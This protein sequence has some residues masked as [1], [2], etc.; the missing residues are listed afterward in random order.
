[1]KRL[2]FIFLIFL[3]T[4]IV[5]ANSLV[6]PFI[7]DD[8]MLIG[9][10]YQIKHHSNFFKIFTSSLA[11][12][13]YSNSTLTIYYRPIQTL[14]YIFDYHIFRLNPWGY[15]L[16]NVLLHVVCVLLIYSFISLLTKDK[17]ISIIT[18][19]LFAVHPIH[20]EAVTYISGRADILAAIFFLLTLIIYIRYLSS[21]KIRG[22]YIF[23]SAFT[24]ILSILCKEVVLVLPFIIILYNFRFLPNKRLNKP[25][26]IYLIITVVYIAVSYFLFGF[27]KTHLLSYKSSL[28]FRIATALKALFIYLGL[29]IFPHG[30]RMERI[31]PII[32]SIWDVSVFLSLLGFLTLVILIIRYRNSKLFFF[33]TFWFLLNSFS[34]SGIPVRLNAV[35][36]EHWLYIP[37]IGYFLIIGLFFRTLQKDKVLTRNA[38]I[39][40]ISV[41][42]LFYSLVTIRQNR[43]WSDEEQF[44]K[45]IIHYSPESSRAH[46]NLAVV[47]QKKNKHDEA[48]KEYKRVQ[49]I[50]PSYFFVYNNLGNLYASKGMY[51]MAEKEYIQSIKNNPDYFLTYNNLGHLYALRQEY[52]KAIDEY[53]KSIRLN[54]FYSESHNNLG[55]AYLESDNYRDAE[56]EFKEALKLN[57]ENAEAYNNFGN[58]YAKINLYDEAIK[59]YQAAI[60]LKPYFDKAHFN[61]GVIY[62]HKNLIEQAEKEWQKVLEINPK[63]AGALGALR[64]R[65][66]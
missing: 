24:Y 27:H 16:S 35:M 22:L 42:A 15:H 39:F 25:L 6:N 41:I 63:H 32:N 17:I 3:I 49:E 47:Y 64:E 40:I 59:Y 29:L 56:R 20:T 21:A 55:L 54:P 31:S 26:V 45:R 65:Q 23:F 19:L 13:P 52:S 12:S 14:T 1:M 51:D 11:P 18:S 60:K 58:L 44:Y 62:F 37:S 53:K 46:F 66:K 8:L 38:L 43:V 4:I 9:E 48:I 28:G 7:W 61:L 30:L 57:P 10:N 34:I 2:S 50:D 36:A 33:A 5:Y